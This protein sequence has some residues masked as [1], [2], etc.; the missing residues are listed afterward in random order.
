MAQV[1]VINGREED[2]FNYTPS[3]AVV[4]GDVI[5]LNG[6][7]GV[8]TRDIAASA[9]GSLSVEGLKYVP[10]TTAAWVVGLPVHWNPTGDPDSGTAGT[11]AANQLGAGTYMGIATIAAASGEDR[12]WVNLNQQ[13]NLLAVAS[14]TAAGSV[15]GDAAQLSQGFNI[16]TGAD[17][18]KGVILPTAVA[19]MVVYVKGVTA[20]VLK[21]WPKTGGTINALSAS[22]ALSLTTGAMP[23]ILIA[24]S[25]TQ[26][27]T[28]PL[29]SS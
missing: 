15:I 18:T 17:G 12:G 4:G 25:A 23:S 21:V 3:G 20:G 26:W 8:A 2:S 9:L 29:V 14:V 11:G 27:Y 13:S 28:I 10:K 6:V 19:G 5:V 7:V 24:T 16:V 22:A 1:P